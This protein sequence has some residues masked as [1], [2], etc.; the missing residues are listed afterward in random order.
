[1]QNKEQEQSYYQTLYEV[2]KVI[3][4]SLEPSTV[5]NKIAEQVTKAMQVK[6]CTI[7][8]L[9]KERTYLLAGASYGLSEGYLRKGR[10]EVA[11]SGIDQEV[12][13]GKNIFIQN[14]CEDPRFQY[15]EEA[16]KECIT[17]VM[18][19]PLQ[20]EGER[21]IGVLRVYAE[22]QREFSDAE[23][24][25]LTAIANISAIAIDNARL[26][27]AL[28]SEYELLTAYEYQLFED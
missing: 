20:A 21:V 23:I 11:K 8:L 25:F 16:R 6:G 26:H 10:I 7:R 14:A 15:P 17:S 12:L 5:L 1:M 13:A 3:N 28:K 4:S 27:Q 22:V 18:A 9:N 19:V 2:A 24:D